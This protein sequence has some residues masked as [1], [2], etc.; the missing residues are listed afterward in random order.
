ML[1][2][3]TGYHSAGNDAG[4][5]Q[6]GSHARTQG[7]GFGAKQAKQPVSGFATLSRYVC[8]YAEGQGREVAPASSFVPRETMPPLT[9]ALHKV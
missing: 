6:K 3:G 5:T 4:V 8:T 7:H 9:D 1:V 2:L